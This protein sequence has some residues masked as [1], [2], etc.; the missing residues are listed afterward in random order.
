MTDYDVKAQKPSTTRGRMKRFE[1][2][3]ATD[4]E[5]LEHYECSGDPDAFAELVRR[6]GQK[7]MAVGLRVHGNESDAEDVRQ[8][9]F[10]ALAKSS[11]GIRD[12]EVVASWLQGVARRAALTI[13]RKNFRWERNKRAM[14]D[15]KTSCVEIRDDQTTAVANEELRVALDEELAK[16]PPKLSTCVMLCDFDGLSQRQAAKQLGV[17]VSTINDRLAQ[18]RKLLQER[19]RRRGIGIGLAAL[20]AAGVLDSK[21]ASAMSEGIVL[22]ITGKATLY[23]AGRTASEIGV[24]STVV[25]TATGISAAMR[26]AKILTIIFGRS[27]VGA[28]WQLNVGRRRIRRW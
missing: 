26:N 16:L 21:C 6:H 11:E 28:F 1:P 23:A 10:M 13:L 8:A 19:F 4:M 22:D 24:T 7:V 2:S 3:A 25:D 20:A 14:E 27:N 9:T 12:E 17:S 15:A 5:L 18:G